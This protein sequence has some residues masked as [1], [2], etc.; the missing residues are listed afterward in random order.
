MLQGSAFIMLLLDIT[1]ILTPKLL[2]HV[3]EDSENWSKIAFFQKNL[4]VLQCNILSNSTK[5]VL[6][7]T[8]IDKDFKMCSGCI[9]QTSG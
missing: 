9:S 2:F 5:Y 6:L 3:A 8:W 7:C 1:R 4:G